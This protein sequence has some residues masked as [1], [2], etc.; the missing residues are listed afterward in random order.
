MSEEEFLNRILNKIAKEFGYD[1]ASTL[2]LIIITKDKKVEQLEKELQITANKCKQLENIRK[3]AIKYMKSLE[4]EPDAD[5]YMEIG[6]YSEYK[7][8]LNILNK[9]DNK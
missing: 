6:E 1:V 8:L 4:N 3:E 5:M 7:Y 9:G 2:E